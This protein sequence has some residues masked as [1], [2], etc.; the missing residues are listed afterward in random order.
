MVAGSGAGNRIEAICAVDGVVFGQQKG[1]TSKL[2][3]ARIARLR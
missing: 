1:L 3:Y 2:G